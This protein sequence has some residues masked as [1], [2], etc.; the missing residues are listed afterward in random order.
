MLRIRLRDSWPDIRQL[1][2]LSSLHYKPQ[3][4]VRRKKF[5][6]SLLL[7]LASIYL[8]FVVILYEY[9]TT[10]LFMVLW[11]DCLQIHINNQ[12][13]AVNFSIHSFNV[14]VLDYPSLPFS[15]PF[16]LPSLPSPPFPFSPSFLSFP[17]PLHFPLVS[18]NCQLETA[19]AYLNEDL[20]RSCRPIGVSIE[21]L[22]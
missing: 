17:S 13:S 9:V 4:P 7:N 2:H 1:P 22:Y 15:S 3:D 14:F 8:F 5:Y 12:N 10:Y 18:I 11:T 16:F 6:P 21:W 20:C 19:Q